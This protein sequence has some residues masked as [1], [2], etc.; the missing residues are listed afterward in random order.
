MECMPTLPLICGIDLINVDLR[1]LLARLYMDSLTN[2]MSRGQIKRAL[3]GLTRG[4]NGLDATYEE[5]MARIEGQ[6]R[7]IRE[8]AKQVL[9]WITCAKRPLT[10]LELQHALAVEIGQSRFDEDFLPDIEVMVSVCAGLVTIDAETAIIRLAHYTMQ[11]YF[12]RT[13]MSWFPDAQRDIAATC[14]TYLS[15]DIFATG[16]C[17]TD[18]EFEVRLL[19]YPLYD[20][21]A[22]NWGNH[23]RAASREVENL[24]LGLLE[25]EAKVSA[26]NQAM[27][28]SRSCSGYSQRAPRQTTGVHLAAYFGLTGVTMALLRSMH[29]PDVKDTYDRTPLSWAAEKGHEAV[30]KLLLDHGADVQSKDKSGRVPLSWAIEKG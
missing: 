19:S 29:D 4:I 22:R 14:V 17:P 2:Q 3:Q 1:F 30:V 10:T 5:A 18:E 24:I 13:Q 25:S 15:F 11:D 9:S 7:E 28:A 12:E 26:V 16:F 27:L 8:L 6:E 23:A 21:A 20:Y